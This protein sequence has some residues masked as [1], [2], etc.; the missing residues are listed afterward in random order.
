MLVQ[1][2]YK[3]LHRGALY[4][5]QKGRSVRYEAESGTVCAGA[6]LSISTWYRARTVCCTAYTSVFSALLFSS[7]RRRRVVMCKTRCTCLGDRL[8]FPQSEP[9]DSLHSEV[10]AGSAC[11]LDPWILKWERYVLP[12]RRYTS[13]GLTTDKIAAFTVT[14]RRF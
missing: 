12:Q 3:T 10:R 1:S 14:A 8:V 7:Q 2:F 6:G 9:V 5:P 11:L 4:E 13:R